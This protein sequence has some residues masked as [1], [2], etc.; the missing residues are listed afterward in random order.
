MADGQLAKNSI[1]I[2]IK[3]FIITGFTNKITTIG[4]FLH[5]L[6]CYSFITTKT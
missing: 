1:L 5:N 2:T 6:K 3:I 4:R